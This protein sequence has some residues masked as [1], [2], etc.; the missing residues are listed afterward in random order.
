M[1]IKPT[2]IIIVILL[3]L[4]W[5][6]YFTRPEKTTIVKTEKEYITDTIREKV[7]KDVERIKWKTKTVYKTI[8]DLDTI[9]DTVVLVESQKVVIHDL[10]EINQDQDTT[11]NKL[12]KLDTLNKEVIQEKNTE[13]VKKQ[14]RINKL[15]KAL[16]VSLAALGVFITKELLKL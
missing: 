12:L 1:K 14:K 2:Y 16:K 13:I 4:L 10:V 6:G 7:Y 8:H 3:F 11:I 5:L 9:H 15:G